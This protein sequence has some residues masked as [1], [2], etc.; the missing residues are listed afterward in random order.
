MR[1][2]LSFLF[3]CICTTSSLYSQLYEPLYNVSVRGS[4]G[5]TFS[6]G[7]APQ[8]S[9]VFLCSEYETTLNSGYEIVA[10]IERGFGEQVGS[11]VKRSQFSLG[12][13]VGFSKRNYNF[14]AVN[15]FP[16]WDSLTSS[17]STLSIQSDFLV[18]IQSVDAS[19][20]LLYRLPAFLPKSQT[21][22]VIGISA[23]FPIA[24]SFRQTESILSPRNVTFNDNG[25]PRRSLTVAEGNSIDAFPAIYRSQI[26]IVNSVFVSRSI[27]LLQRIEFQLYSNPVQNSNTTWLPSTVQCSLG[28][29]YT[30]PNSLNPDSPLS[31]ANSKK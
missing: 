27:E 19:L 4:V 1:K 16:F 26:G 9:G 3:V 23:I 30:L 28:I 20:E 14:D 10:G 24:T 29:S 17:V 2:L 21:K 13:S 18:Q 22:I 25:N 11:L 6:Y 31:P 5:P 12:A 15:S 8:F 7:T